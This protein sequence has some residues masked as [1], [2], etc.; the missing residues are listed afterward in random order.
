MDRYIYY[1]APVS[2]AAEV[3]LCVQAMQRQLA[4]QTGVC[5]ELK[6]RPEPEAAQHTWMEVYHDIPPGFDAALHQAAQQHAL[7][8]W[9]VGARHT[10]DFLNPAEWQ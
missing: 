8:T 3:Q 7:A 5:C 1:R 6:R 4:Q 10:D 2:Q 9:I